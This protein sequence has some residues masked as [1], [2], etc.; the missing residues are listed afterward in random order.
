MKFDALGCFG[1]YAEEGTPAAKMTGQVHEKVKNERVERLMLTQ[2]EIAFEKGRERIGQELVCL[3]D[4]VDE[5]GLGHGRFY[6]QAPDIDSICYIRDCSAN[7]SEFIRVEVT[8]SQDYD[9]L[10]RQIL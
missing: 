1:F 2:Q 5:D 3:I 7:A 9:L 4:E 8:G 10:C 6:G